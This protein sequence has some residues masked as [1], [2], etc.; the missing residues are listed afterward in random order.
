MA[1]THALLSIPPDLRPHLWCKAGLNYPPLPHL[2]PLTAAQM[3]SQAPTLIRDATFQWNW[4]DRPKPGSG[5]LVWMPQMQERV[6]PSDGMQWLGPEV[7][8][9]QE[10]GG[11]EGL[12]Q[13]TVLE[14]YESKYGWDPTDPSAA[15]D[16]A[17]TTT[18]RRYRLVR[19]GNEQLWFIHYAAAAEERVLADIQSSRPLPPRRYPLPN[20][21]QSPLFHLHSEPGAVPAA[22]AMGPPPSQQQ[23]RKRQR[24][25]PRQGGPREWQAMQ[26]DL[27]EDVEGDD[28]DTLDPVVVA[29]ARYI[30]RHEWMEEIFGSVYPTSQILRPTPTLS[31]TDEEKAAQTL[32]EKIAALQREVE[33]M[34]EAHAKTLET[35]TGSTENYAAATKALSSVKNLN[36]IA[37]IQA[38][39]EGKMGVRTMERPKVRAV[40]V[41]V[42]ATAAPPPPRDEQRVS[43]EPTESQLGVEPVVGDVGMN[44]MEEDILMRV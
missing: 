4:I 9:V 17:T 22:L 16:G 20:L 38:E 19:G 40:Y 42:K 24:L 44:V 10:F 36:D 43:E 29:Q 6:P 7:L 15:P 34:K 14:F 31:G 13:G 11:V 8:H 28:L 27:S 18:R 21:A 33:E 37:T 35:F 12:G 5:Y 39:V 1:A 26:E 32:A 25:D 30:R 41:E 2:S 3:L 23:P